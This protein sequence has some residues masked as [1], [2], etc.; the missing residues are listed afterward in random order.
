MG[1]SEPPPEHMNAPHT[2]LSSL[3]SFPRQ[4]T[5]QPIIRDPRAE[6]GGRTKKCDALIMMG[7]E[8]SG[9]LKM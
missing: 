8:V 2:K 7:K 5:R 3:A 6:D 9:F 4:K 1:E